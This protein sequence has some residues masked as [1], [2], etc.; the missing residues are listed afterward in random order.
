MLKGL[1]KSALNGIK[2]VGSGVK[3]IYNKSKSKL[4]TIKSI[5]DIF[6][7]SNEKSN[8]GIDVIGKKKDN[9]GRGIVKNEL[10]EA[11]E[12]FRDISISQRDEIVNEYGQG[13]LN[14]LI[15]EDNEIIQFKDVNQE[16]NYEIINMYCDIME[17]NSLKDISYRMT[18]DYIN[19][20]LGK[21]FKELEYSPDEVD[22]IKKV[23]ESFEGNLSDMYDFIDY[24]TQPQFTNDYDSDA[25]KDNPDDY[26]DEMT[27]RLSEMEKLIRTKKYK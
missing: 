18:Q 3:S 1:I 8:I 27:T 11:R 2:K 6:K 17:E 5:K 22:R 16:N 23:A 14:Y 13:T 7:K 20:F 25:G 26:Y 4:K 19:E 24:V 10:D 15:M 9:T 21:Y 12:R